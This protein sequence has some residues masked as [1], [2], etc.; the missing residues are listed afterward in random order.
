LT[1]TYAV[2]IVQRPILTR[3]I[4]DLALPYSEEELRAAVDAAPIADTQLLKV[5]VKDADPAVAAAIANRLT[6]LLLQNNESPS[7][8]G[9]VSVAEPP[10]PPVERT[11]PQ[12]V[13]TAIL[14]AMIGLLSAGGIIFLLDHLDSTVKTVDDLT[15]LDLWPLG[16]VTK[17][18]NPGKNG[19]AGALDLAQDQSDGL[20]V[21][22]YRILSTNVQFAMMNRVKKIVLVTSSEP[23]EGKSTVA[24]NLATAIAQ[25]GVKIILVDADLRRPVLHRHFNLANNQGLAA[26]LAGV[27]GK[28][29]DFLHG[30]ATAN[31]QVLPS[32]SASP[33]RNPTELLS[34]RKMDEVLTGLSQ[35]AELVI[36]DSPPLHA[37]VDAS[38][39][40][41]SAGN[42]LLV[43][44]SGK[45]SG[46][47]IRRSLELLRRLNVTTLGAV[48]NKDS[49]R[50]SRYYRYYAPIT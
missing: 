23:L 47:S 10:F 36:I 17:F 16:T 14:A 39:L 24:V 15:A 18:K 6:Q 37:V 45:T 21:E 13:R 11:E 40:A 25:A 29:C 30:T 35:L 41:A 8:P 27:S 31:L 19:A 48:L 7:R 28:L 22:Q 46:E 26:L 12:P 50:N 43:I 3:V 1:N 49:K 20:A 33:L 42:V 32:G 38:I 44:E 2:L 5:S 34:S 9:T 4:A